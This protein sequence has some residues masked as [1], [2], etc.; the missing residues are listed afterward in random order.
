MVWMAIPPLAS[1][2]IDADKPWSTCTPAPPSCPLSYPPRPPFHL[3]WTMVTTRRQRLP[4]FSLL[5]VHTEPACHRR[6]LQP[7][8]P[9]RQ[10]L[11]FPLTPPL[12]DPPWSPPM[13]TVHAGIGT[14]K[15]ATSPSRAGDHRQWGGHG[16]TL[17]CH[18]DARHLRSLP[19][20]RTA[21]SLTRP[22]SPSLDL[23]SLT[24]CVASLFWS[25]PTRA[26]SQRL[27]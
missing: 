17:T 7:S 12:P 3:V 6:L 13:S 27:A 15:L 8:L 11:G 2:Q 21:P 20:P 4:P 24:P 25:L 10:R 14:A 16:R 1:T 19:S 5:R 22:V 23:L 9:P 18:G 26:S